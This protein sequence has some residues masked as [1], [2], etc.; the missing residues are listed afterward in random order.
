MQ[1]TR[2][3]KGKGI[4]YI[5]RVFMM[6]IVVRQ[7]PGMSSLCSSRVGGPALHAGGGRH[8]IHKIRAMGGVFKRNDEV[9][10]EAGGALLR[11]SVDNIRSSRFE[12]VP[13]V[14]VRG[15]LGC[16][17]CLLKIHVMDRSI[18]G[19]ATG[20]SIEAVPNRIVKQVLAIQPIAVH[21]ME[22]EG[23]SKGGVARALEDSE[24]GA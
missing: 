23:V 6:G 22:A 19:K 9:R 12:G 18:V 20:N 13:V 8:E 2:A 10:A 16:R 15:G 7:F 5:S 1:I 14:N 17:V 11:N 4:K 21:E 24:N 3:L